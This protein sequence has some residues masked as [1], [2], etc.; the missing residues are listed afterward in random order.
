M[1]WKLQR[2]C[3]VCAI[4][5]SSKESRSE[6]IECPER[7]T[8]VL[9][10]FFASITSNLSQSPSRILLAFAAIGAHETPPLAPGLLYRWGRF[11]AFC[12]GSAGFSSLIALADA[13]GSILILATHLPAYWGLLQRKRYGVVFHGIG[14]LLWI[15][16]TFF[17][18]TPQESPILDTIRFVIQL[19][20]LAINIVYFAPRWKWMS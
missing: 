13:I 3:A 14:A 6:L 10:I 2:S 7:L 16:L 1:I 12:T 8:P 11:I 15:W 4:A 9:G 20:Y 18:A 17:E 19:G 5:C